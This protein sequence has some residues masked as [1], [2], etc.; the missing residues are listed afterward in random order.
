MGK[1]Q[2][3][4]PVSVNG[5]INFIKENT[6]QQQGNSLKKAFDSARDGGTFLPQGDFIDPH[7]L[8]ESYGAEAGFRFFVNN[9]ANGTPSYK[10][11]RSTAFY[12]HFYSELKWYMETGGVKHSMVFPYANY[13]YDIA[14]SASSNGA[15]GSG[16]STYRTVESKLYHSNVGKSTNKTS[17]FDGS[18]HDRIVENIEDQYNGFASAYGDL[19]SIY[20]YSWL[21][22][23]SVNVGDQLI[24]R[25]TSATNDYNSLPYTV[26]STDIDSFEDSSGNTVYIRR[27]YVDGDIRY[28]GVGATTAN[29]FR[30]TQDG[31]HVAIANDYSDANISPA[32]EDY[33]HIL[34]PW[35]TYRAKT[36]YSNQYDDMIFPEETAFQKSGGKYLVVNAVAGEGVYGKLDGWGTSAYFGYG[37]NGFYQQQIAGYIPTIQTY[38]FLQITWHPLY[39]PVYTYYHPTAQGSGGV[40]W[41]YHVSASNSQNNVAHPSSR[42]LYDEIA[43]AVPSW[44]YAPSAPYAY[45]WVW[46]H[47]TG[48]PIPLV[49]LTEEYYYLEKL[50]NTIHKEDIWIRSLLHLL[51]DWHGNIFGDYHDFFKRKNSRNSSPGDLGKGTIDNSRL[52][53]I[54]PGTSVTDV[55]GKSM[56]IESGAAEFNSSSKGPAHGHWNGMHHQLFMRRLSS[57][58]EKVP[59]YLRAGDHG[60]GYVEVTPES[61]LRYH[62]EKI[63]SNYKIIEESKVLL[64][65][66]F[67]EA[68]Q[69]AGRT[70][71]KLDP[72]QGW[73][74]LWNEE[75]EEWDGRISIIDN[76]GTP[77]YSTSG[78]LLSLASY[79]E[80]I[81]LNSSVF[82][83]YISTTPGV[84]A[85]ISMKMA[86]PV[87]ALIY[88]ND[89]LFLDIPSNPSFVEY[90]FSFVPQE[91]QVKLSICPK[92]IYPSTI[93]IDTI[94]VAQAG[95]TLPEQYFSKADA[96]EAWK[97]LHYNEHDYYYN[98]SYN[99]SESI[100]T[101][102]RWESFTLSLFYENII[103][104][105]K[106]HRLSLSDFA[107]S[108]NFSASQSTRFEMQF[109]INKSNGQKAIASKIIEIFPSAPAKLPNSGEDDVFRSVANVFKIDFIVRDSGNTG[110]TSGGWQI[111]A[112]PYTGPTS[113]NVK[114]IML[115]LAHDGFYTSDDIDCVYSYSRD[116]KNWVDF[117]SVDANSDGSC[118]IYIP[119]NSQAF[120][121]YPTTNADQY[122]Y[123][124]ARWIAGPN[125]TGQLPGSIV[126]EDIVYFASIADNGEISLC[127]SNDFHYYA[128]D[129]DFQP[130]GSDGTTPVSQLP[131]SNGFIFIFE[132]LKTLRPNFGNVNSVIFPDTQNSEDIEGNSPADFHWQI[133]YPITRG[134]SLENIENYDLDSDWNLVQKPG[135]RIYQSS[136]Q[137]IHNL[138]VDSNNNTGHSWSGPGIDSYPG[139]SG[140]EVYSLGDK[141]GPF[142]K[143]AKSAISFIRFEALRRAIT[144][145]AVRPELQSA[146]V[147]ILF[148][149][150]IS[151]S[152]IGIPNS[153]GE[154]SNGWFQDLP[155]EKLI[156][157]TISISPSNTSGSYWIAAGTNT[158]FKREILGIPSSVPD[159]S[160][161]SFP[162]VIPS[163]TDY[164]IKIAGL[165]YEVQ[166]ITNDFQLLLRTQ[167]QVAYNN[168][169]AYVSYNDNE[170]QD[171]TSQNIY[172][173]FGVRS[174]DSENFVWYN[175]RLIGVAAVTWQSGETLPTGVSVG[176][177]KP[178]AVA[179]SIH[180][181]YLDSSSPSLPIGNYDFTDVNSPINITTAG[182]DL[183]PQFIVQPEDKIWTCIGVVYSQD[184][185]STNTS[186]NFSIGSQ[187]GASSV[188]ESSGLDPSLIDD[189]PAGSAQIGSIYGP[190]YENIQYIPS[191]TIR[192]GELTTSGLRLRMHFLID[193]PMEDRLQIE[194][195]ARFWESVILDDIDID[196]VIMPHPTRSAGGTLASATPTEYIIG[197]DSAFHAQNR[198]QIKEMYVYLDTDDIIP[199]AAPDSSFTATGRNLVVNGVVPGGNRLCHIM[200]HEIAH[201]L[202]IGSAWNVEF[203]GYYDDQYQWGFANAYGSQYNGPNAIREYQNIVQAAIDTPGMKI[204]VYSDAQ[205]DFIDEDISNYTFYT[206]NVPIESLGFGQDFESW[207]DGDV[208]GGHVAEY[209][210][211]VGSTIQP[212]FVELMSSIYDVDESLISR[213]TLGFL[214]DLGYQVDYSK[215]PSASEMHTR[216]D[217]YGN[218]IQVP[219]IGYTGIEYLKRYFW[220]ELTD[221]ERQEYGSGD[222]ALAQFISEQYDSAA[223]RLTDSKLVQ[224]NCAKH[225]SHAIKDPIMPYGISE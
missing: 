43:F 90:N 213:L 49:K 164:I 97:K 69:V 145:Y 45:P 2:T 167:V 144:E 71:E 224:C 41:W 124:R 23:V 135:K 1:F 95:A 13:I 76:S 51:N 34:D 126:A 61:T 99:A 132:G 130:V 55:S 201:G 31:A 101:N 146:E 210:K 82:Y 5:F 193:L 110:P 159:S 220:K 191:A 52:T 212:T 89:V 59:F 67:W 91:Y 209:A 92:E 36:Y 115:T 136:W 8:S 27:A 70:I 14:S 154:D 4:G 165:S 157:G 166:E 176:D 18:G 11:S 129:K 197:E 42:G 147:R 68:D 87:N 65:E 189:S 200:I 175:P 75:F 208:S 178:L 194:M 30:I 66:D 121:P 22:W 38:P 114:D 6:A 172:S 72:P 177:V 53:L 17:F 188:Y 57:Y 169:T 9:D 64:T 211:K 33:T 163:G 116:K 133:T 47:M 206:D 170:L 221:T 161:P 141:R 119:S 93:Q 102:V 85:V 199:G 12:G 148:K 128:T 48:A 88:I 127:H 77:V 134:K 196:V 107:V 223:D 26:T 56:L 50:Y 160:L 80:N 106:Q 46:P 162:Y 125:S 3:E 109:Y 98:N 44:E 123:Y 73:Y 186:I 20:S 81:S 214:E 94:K 137:F 180:A 104:T 10:S 202:G 181:Y 131:N 15:A 215:V 140:N 139:M 84:E 190:I 173:I 120:P 79:N 205:Q 32:N 60:H 195:A 155:L 192:N 168:T 122:T 117:Q 185:S 204:R 207:Q 74:S 21:V 24:V 103:F 105:D 7:A 156:S 16:N 174:G 118:T 138:R 183:S 187:S 86:L 113:T 171:F 153:N 63:G 25:Y 151:S 108:S 203:V 217:V 150:S 216:T 225:K 218:T 35:V 62:I 58:P 29:I 219:L 78:E 112:I 111:N 96:I 19:I 83:T 152:G 149:R 54:D 28:T 198:A 179:R 184:G 143:Y 39:T 158:S 142:S 40:H 100:A 37:V 222:S 182:W